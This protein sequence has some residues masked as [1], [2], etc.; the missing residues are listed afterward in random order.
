MHAAAFIVTTQ[1]RVSPRTDGGG[2]GQLFQ[3]MPRQQ[4]GVHELRDAGRDGAHGGA[5]RQAR[6]GGRA[7]EKGCHH[8]AREERVQALAAEEANHGAHSC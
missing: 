8:R 4:A 1:R 2:G 7:P 6:A 5:H 3:Q